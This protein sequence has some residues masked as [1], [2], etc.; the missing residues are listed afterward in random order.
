MKFFSAMFSPL[1]FLRYVF[2]A[3]TDDLQKQS[4]PE[5]RVSRPWQKVWLLAILGL[6]V[7]L[8]ILVTQRL[9]NPPVPAAAM[10]EKMPRQV[11]ADGY[12]SSDACRECHPGQHASWHDSYHRTMTQVASPTSILAPFTGE[13]AEVEDVK[14][15]FKRR[16]GDYVIRVETAEDKGV[17]RPIVMTTGSHHMQL[18]WMATGWERQLEMAPFVYLK[19]DQRWVPRRASFLQPPD[20]EVASEAGRWNRGCIRCHTTHGVPGIA[21]MQMETRV[22]EFGIACEACHGPGENHVRFHRSGGQ[23]S[24]DDDIVHPAQLSHRQSSQICGRCHVVSSMVDEADYLEN[25]LSYRPGDDLSTVR[26]VGHSEFGEGHFWPDG[27]VRTSGREFN[28]VQESPCYQRG[29]LSCLS[30]HAMHK[31][32]DDP[33]TAEQWADDQLLY[34]STGNGACLQCHTEFEDAKDLAQ[35]THHA[36]DSTGSMCYNCHMPHTAYGLLKA[37]RSHQIDNPSVQVSIDTGRP[38]ACNLCHLDKSLGWTADYLQRWYGISSPALSA[39]QRHT[40]AALQ[41]L[42]SGDAGQRALLAWHMGW[43]PAQK[44]SGTQWLAPHLAQ[45]L[46]DPYDAVRYIT[47]RSLRSLPGFDA[48][49]YDF[50]SDAEDLAAARQ[51]AVAIW[52]QLPKVPFP[53][54]ESLMLDEQGNLRHDEIKKLI[55]SRSD[56]EVRLI[57]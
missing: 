10:R 8:G 29:K 21:Y 35:H 16:G 12:V 54:S 40:S 57:E 45:L 50:L 47:Q 17:E 7:G 6:I 24:K 2:S 25:G 49:P 36:A 13:Q 19:E 22:A 43:Q 46:E 34:S 14:A 31:P 28:A 5:D 39:S 3:M 55:D 51:E 20:A 30:C 4:P 23:L 11:S 44:T 38:N 33:R 53:K 1:C 32:D 18:C 37:S 41:W 56:R 15:T 48:F 27:V 26:N 42:L 52:S 9:Q